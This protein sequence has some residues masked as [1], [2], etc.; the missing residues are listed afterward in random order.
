MLADARPSWW[1]AACTPGPGFAPRS[2]PDDRPAHHE[3]Q[4]GTTA[5]FVTAKLDQRG[6]SCGVAAGASEQS[7]AD[8]GAGRKMILDLNHG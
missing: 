2:T 7:D 6:H 4:R 8:E 5:W 3:E 1:S